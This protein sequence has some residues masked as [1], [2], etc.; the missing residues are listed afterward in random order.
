MKTL[1]VADLRKPVDQLT[2]A[3]K[4]L[5]HPGAAEHCAICAIA[6]FPWRAWDAGGS[7]LRLGLAA[8]RKM[9]LTGSCR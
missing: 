9:A 5:L 2:E 8:E 1:P 7:A 4:R 3:Y 6:D